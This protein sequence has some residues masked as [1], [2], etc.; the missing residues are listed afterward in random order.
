MQIKHN[1]LITYCDDEA[2]AYKDIHNGF[3]QFWGQRTHVTACHRT[4]ITSLHFLR[5]TSATFLMVSL[6]AAMSSNLA[7]IFS[8]TI[9]TSVALV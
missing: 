6:K 2:N 5:M 7:K 9:G 3:L 1:I 8:F 4:L